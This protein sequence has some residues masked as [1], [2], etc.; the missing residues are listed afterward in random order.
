M[1]ALH[2]WLAPLTLT[3]A[4]TLAA[5]AQA[6]TYAASFALGDEACDDFARVRYLHLREWRS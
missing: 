4:T 5:H 1:Q 6:L 2:R 3:L